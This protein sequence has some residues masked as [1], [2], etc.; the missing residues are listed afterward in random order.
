MVLAIGLLTSVLT[1]GIVLGLTAVT[2]NHLTGTSKARPTL[3][4][5]GQDINTSTILTENTVGIIYLGD[6]FHLVANLTNGASN[7]WVTFYD[8]NEQIMR[9]PTIDGIV[10]FDYPEN[11]LAWNINAT[12]EY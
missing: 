12:A 10:S 1:A 2:S 3:I 7:V 9:A 6:I 8:N 5:T 4:L 11:N